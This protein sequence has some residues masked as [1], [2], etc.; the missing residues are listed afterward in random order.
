MRHSWAYSML[1]ETLT[2]VFV[3][4]VTQERRTKKNPL[5]LPVTSSPQLMVIQSSQAA[6]LAPL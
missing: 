6:L 2:L 4:A 5:M 1:G 3:P